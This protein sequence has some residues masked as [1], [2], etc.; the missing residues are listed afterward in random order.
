MKR[1]P[2][3]HQEYNDGVSMCP[4]DGQSL[5]LNPDPMLG[6]LLEGKYRLESCIGVGGMATVY[7]ATRTQIGDN[8]AVKILNE[9]SLKNPLAVARFR[10]E[11]QAAARIH[12]NS[13]VT[14]HDMGNLPEGNT[15][16]V[17]EYIRGHS[18]RDELKQNKTLSVARAISLMSAV[19]N[20]VHAA[21]DAGIIHR[22]LKPEN[23]MVQKFSD[24]SETVKVVDF[25]VAELR[26]HV[27]SDALTKLTEAG[28][29]VGTPYYI[30]PE[31]CR[32]EPLDPR[33]D[34]Y[35]LGIILYELLAG[36]VPFRGR[37]LSAVIIQHA[38][39]PPPLLR[40]IRPDVSEGVESV[41]LR[42]LAKDRNQRPVTSREMGQLLE[43][44]L[45]G[46]TLSEPVDII[47][48][49]IPHTENHNTEQKFSSP[50]KTGA[51]I[52][53]RKSG[54]L[55]YDSLTGLH[56]HAFFMRNLEE[57]TLRCA[58]LNE[59]LG[60]IIF[61][62]DKFKRINNTYGYL[63]GDL[64]LREVGHLLCQNLPE[65]MVLCR[66]PGDGFT[67]MAVTKQSELVTQLATKLILKIKQTRFLTKELPEGLEITLSAGVAFYPEDTLDPIDLFEIAKHSLATAKTIG[68]GQVARKGSSGELSYL[69]NQNEPQIQFESFVGRSIELEKLQRG[70]DQSVAGR[71]RFVLI[72]GD[73][74]L[75]KTRLVE[76]FRRQLAG[77]DVL[78][79]QSRFYESGGSIPYKAFCDSLRGSLHYLME[80]T[81]EDTQIVFGSMA[82][83]VITD[84]ST[85][86]PLS[87]LLNTD[88][89]YSANAEQE[90]YRIFDYLV[91]I[92]LNLSKLRPIIL[93]LD[94]LQWADELTLDFLAYLMRNT[95]GER[96]FFLATSRE[97]ELTNESNPVRGWLRQMSRYGNQEQIKLSPL[98]E[99]EIAKVM[100]SMFGS[101]DISQ[102]ML[103]RLCQETKG[104]PFYFNEIIR[105]LLEEKAI[106]WFDGCWHCK[107]VNEIR[108]P[109]SVV[110]LVEAHL[111]KLA[112]QDL[113]VFTQ[114]AILGDEFTFETL[115]AV[116]EIDED[117]LL[118][119]IEAG[120]REYI[121]REEPSTREDRYSFY[122]STVRKVLYERTSRRRR[123]RLHQQIG[124]KLEGLY[125]D[126]A[127]KIA[128]ELV[129]HYYNAED[130]EH[131]LSYA[132]EAGNL[133][134]RAMA[135]SEAAKYY[136]WAEKSI[137]NLT[138]SLKDESRTTGSNQVLQLAACGLQI[139]ADRMAQYHLNYGQLFMQLGTHQRAES[140]LRQT[141]DLARQ[142]RSLKLVGRAFTALGELYRQYGQLSRGLEYGEQ[143]LAVL[144]S[145][146]DSEWEVQSLMVIGASHEGL[147]HFS[148]A[149]EQYEGALVLA[150]KIKDRFQ[151][152]NALWGMGVIYFRLGQY[153][154]AHDSAKRALEISTV[155]GDRLGQERSHNLI[156]AI[157]LEIGQFQE[158]L[159][160]FE[161]ALKIARDMGYRLR[162]TST[163]NNIGEHYRRQMRHQEAYE[164][165]QQALSITKE[166]LDKPTQASILLNIGLLYQSQGNHETALAE[167]IKAQKIIQELGL[168]PTE[169][170]TLVAIGDSL[171]AINNI[172]DAQSY[173]QY[174]LDL[175]RQ[176]GSPVCE[177]RAL[178]GL[179]RCEI[180]KNHKNTALKLLKKTVEVIDSMSSELATYAN[181]VSFLKNKQ[182]VYNDLAELAQELS[183]DGVL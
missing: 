129:Y 159:K 5:M 147:G 86:D 9:E 21:H 48:E 72:T 22:D 143:G 142:V 102:E 110:D 99:T 151:E 146:E 131:A 155:I 69:P 89:N 136:A 138:A 108:L 148:Q 160:N 119:V 56:S 175:S 42:A 59:S 14:I 33:A 173:Y 174:G 52:S 63:L 106:E 134:W 7:L 165:Y 92:Y 45:A 154:K 67:T 126:R 163:L 31:Q 112:S 83:K 103:S 105:L 137:Q 32:G 122:H 157:L 8:V 149:L 77:K 76:E 35:S 158:A 30:S 20:A 109:T 124:N 166:T 15:F 87:L 178:Y 101:I 44:A 73:A 65:Q 120:L 4:S 167:F 127:N 100:E 13:V 121:L 182:I 117:Q 171:S 75:G 17:M 29:M 68:A 38:T 183:K 26:E 111:I 82:D 123:K 114:A 66:A 34:I 64:L 54:L 91:R 6:K 93:F 78:F 162:E 57:N 49:A 24:D 179:A 51:N 84:F 81:P 140:Q 168:R 25:G 177:W 152:S 150:R 133:A 95:T 172:K 11:A 170:E 60:V 55:N 1:C 61:G 50:S 161:K 104:N 79:L 16:L 41:I 37:T 107:D 43:Q 12:H 90:K 113:E 62:V 53:A 97:W 141:L 88:P 39:E 139:E 40:K 96:I 27:I 23:I 58:Q 132:V 145:I 156:G 3:C 130:Y 98:T 70:F 135:F 125:A 46:I 118:G 164:Y 80:Y 28:M 169:L 10:R 128:A 144:T 85:N 115:Q 19:C 176:S 2:N 36:H 47:L 74:G 180:A 94:D 71:G 181:R 18:L 153:D 116:T